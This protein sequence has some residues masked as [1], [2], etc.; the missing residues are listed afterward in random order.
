[1][2]EA[3]EIHASAQIVDA[4]IDLG[5]ILIDLQ[6]FHVGRRR[7][8]IHEGELGDPVRRQCLN[9]A[10]AIGIVGDDGGMTG[11]GR[12]DESRQAGRVDRRIVAQHHGAQVETGD[13]GRRK[14][15]RCDMRE[16]GFLSHE[17]EIARGESS[18][19]VEQR[20]R[21]GDRPKHRQ[22]RTARLGMA[23]GHRFIAP[24]TMSASRRASMKVFN[25]QI[26]CAAPRS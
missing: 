23:L 21:G 9:Q 3:D 11:I 1:M 16:L 6:V 4:D 2:A 26:D 24:A 22:D 14:S 12:V 13:V 25:R 15:G 5:E 8:P 17:F 20:A 18:F 10:L 7:F 19:R